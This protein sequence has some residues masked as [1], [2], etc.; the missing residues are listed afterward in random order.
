M[1]RN[2]VFEKPTTATATATTTATN[3]AKLYSLTEKT[4][5]LGHG[6]CRG[7]DSRSR[8]SL[9]QK[10]DRDRDRDRD[11]D[12]FIT[13][14]QGMGE[15]NFMIEELRLIS[16]QQRN[17]TLRKAK[18]MYMVILKT[19]VYGDLVPIVYCN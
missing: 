17:N 4:A 6:F 16:W 5:N 18:R 15:S 1:C 2:I 8:F 11:H 7:F 13:G 19:L 10:L 12:F 14:L 9:F 3:T